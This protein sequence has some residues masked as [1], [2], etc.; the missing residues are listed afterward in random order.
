MNPKLS[1]LSSFL[2]LILFTGLSAF[3]QQSSASLNI[4]QPPGGEL[5]QD[6]LREIAED[7][8]NLESNPFASDAKQARINLFK[9]ISG[10]PDIHVTICQDV[11]GP[12]VE[13]DNKFKG[14]LLMQFIL[15]SAAYAIE[16]PRDVENDV[17]VTKGGISGSLNTYTIIKK[18][19]GEPA[20]SDFMER[21][22]ELSEGNGLTQYVEKG[23]KKCLGDNR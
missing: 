9:W 8:R 4:A 7:I 17:A 23:V 3:A 15:S 19:E 18:T 12:L 14:E 2:Y 20:T 10:S 21:M 11:I 6:Q 22:S 1:Y 16:N 13:S 5:S